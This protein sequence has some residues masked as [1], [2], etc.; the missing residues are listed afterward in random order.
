MQMDM[1]VVTWGS[2]VLG[3]MY[4]LYMGPVPVFLT[5]A[6]GDTAYAD[7]IDVKF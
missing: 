1:F 2:G 7:F 3:E 6:T 4:T 5:Y